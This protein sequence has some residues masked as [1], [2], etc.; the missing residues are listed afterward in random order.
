MQADMTAWLAELKTPVGIMACNDIR[1]RHIL[2]ACHRLGLK[3]PEDV[4]V[5]GVDNDLML[6]EMSA[7]SLSS[8]E[9]DPEGIGYLAAATL[10]RMMGGDRHAAASWAT[11]AP[12]SVVT[13]GSTDV[14]S[15]TDDAVRR[16][17]RFIRERVAG[18]LK[19]E[20]V[21]THVELSRS[22]LDVRFKHAL[23]RTVHDEIERVRLN[24]AMNLLS[25]TDLPLK[26]VAL[27]CGYRNGAYMAYVFRRHLGLA[28][29][30]YR[31]QRRTVV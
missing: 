19:S 12:K 28:P 10:D 11:V 23:G 18:P 5:L 26:A 9:Q 17:V 31:R 3:V 25:S 21:G 24:T 6:C 30:P 22:A 20:D 13:R 8:I 27:R 15:A 4:A 16:A 7:P 1:A 29:S 2:E 14:I